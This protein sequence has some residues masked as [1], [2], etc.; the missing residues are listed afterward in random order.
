MYCAL[1][2]KSPMKLKYCHLF[3]LDVCI[4]RSGY[5]IKVERGCQ[6]VNLRVTGYSVNWGWQDMIHSDHLPL[7]FITLAEREKDHLFSLLECTNL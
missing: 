3:E 7:I 4:W 5:N 2:I 1:I 6:N